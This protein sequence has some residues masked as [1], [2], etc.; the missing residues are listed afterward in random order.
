MKT[1]P[2]LVLPIVALALGIL[3][4]RPFAHPHELA[5][6]VPDTGAVAEIRKEAV[7]LEPLVS[8]KLA[9]DFLAATLILRPVSPRT[10]YHDS[11]RTRYWNAGEASALPPRTRDS[12]VTRV[13]DESFYY[14]TRY[15]T[16]LAYARP[17][18]IL[19]KAGMSDMDGKKVADFGYGT[20]G[21]L[22]L[23]ASM[24]AEV[25]GIEVDPLLR[26]LYTEPGDQ[27]EVQGISAAGSVKLIH[28][29][30]PAEATTV[31]EAGA[32]YDLFLSKNTLKN[33]Y[34]H[35]AEPVDP[36]RLVHLGVDDTTFVRT[37]FRIV[38]PGGRV[39]I[40]NLCPAPAP[41]GKPYIPWADG[42]SPFSKSLWQS[43]GFRILAFDRDD[44]PAARS[45]AHALGWDQGPSPM[46]LEK[47]LFGI[48]TLV[49]KPKR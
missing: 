15:G 18:E 19:A 22:K 9:R 49:E 13:L 48:Y 21:H 30:F 32:G 47:D 35:P 24:G 20:I 5:A 44:S 10:V 8:T 29:R 45:M 3:V 40:Y 14:T 43:A 46:D 42:R 6:A 28:G 27:G 34:I 16:P 23:F 37:L 2:E 7:A 39:L 11:A 36:R 41:P 4:S 25:V 31:T 1:P 12:L 17:L 26:A 38:K 33:G